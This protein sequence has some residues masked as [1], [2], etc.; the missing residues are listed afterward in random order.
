MHAPNPHENDSPADRR[1]S[2]GLTLAAV[3]IVAC[4]VATLAACGFQLRGMAEL[5]EQFMQT[6]LVGIEP[7]S[8]MG[9]ALRDTFKI[10]GASVGASEVGATAVLDIERTS[11]DR[12][13]LGVSGSGRAQSFQL[14]YRVRFSARTPDGEEL[15]G[16]QEIEL[17]QDFEYEPDQLLSRENA[18]ETA[19]RE[20]VRRATWQI[21][22]R[23]S[24][25][26]AS[27]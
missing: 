25:A 10:N 23:L 14:S 17:F 20:M 1:G 9:I 22:E 27:V 26:P 4:S 6:Q 2:R 11:R 16:S 12:K 5:P 24:R 8:D 18:E 7:F 19:Y 3:V 21:V 13:V 15:V